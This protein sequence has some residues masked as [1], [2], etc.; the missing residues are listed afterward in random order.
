MGIFGSCK[1]PDKFGNEHI[2]N[3]YG[4]EERHKPHRVGQGILLSVDK[5]LN[6]KVVKSS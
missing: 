3:L 4:E 2:E 6:E 5:L 1:F